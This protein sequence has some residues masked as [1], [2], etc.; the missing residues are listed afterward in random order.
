LL[1]HL[2]F[3]LTYIWCYSA[4]TINLNIRKH[5]ESALEDYQK[6]NRNIKLEMM[7]STHHQTIRFSLRESGGIFADKVVYINLTI[8]NLRTKDKN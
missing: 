1:S 2:S 3:R 8:A 7:H 6:E 4:L 5:T